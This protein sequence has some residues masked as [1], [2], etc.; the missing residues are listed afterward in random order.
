[1]N[2]RLPLNILITISLLITH[3]VCGQSSDQQKITLEDIFVK[4]IFSP[5]TLRG[6]NWMDDGQYYT[7]QVH[8]DTS[9]YE[10]ILKYD[11]TSG[12]VVDT[13]V[14]G[15][16][17][18]LE[19]EPVA[20]GV[21]ATG[22]PAMTFMGYT[23]SP[24]QQ[25]V[26]LATE[27]EPIYRRSS[28]AYYYLYDIA[29][30]NFQPLVSG[31]KQSYATFSPDGSKVAF[32]RN[33]N[34]FVV[35]LADMSVKQITQNGEKNQIINGSTDWVYE[36]E[37]GFAK[38]FYWSPESDKLAFLTFDESAVKEYNMQ[39][40]GD[41]YPDDYTFKYPKA[42]EKNS[43]LS[44]SVYHLD[45]DTTIT[46]NTGEEEDMYIP[47]VQWTQDDNI[48]S[49]IRLNRLQNQMELLHANATT[50]QTETILTE[51][52]DTYVD[53][54][55]NDALTYLENGE[56]FIHSS[57]K[58]GYKHLYLYNIDGSLIRQ[59]T[60]GDW[61]VSNFLGIDEQRN[62]LYYL[63]TEVSP[64]QRHLYSINLKG[65][66]KKKLTTQA[67]TYDANF[68]PDFRYYIQYYS[69]TMQP[70][71]ISLHQAPSGKLVRVVED[72]Q[73]LQED[74]ANYNLASKEFFS[75]TTDDQVTL[76]GYMIKPADFDSTKQYPVLMYV[77]GGPGS[78]TVINN[79]M[80]QRE[81]WFYFLAQKGYIV[82]SVDNR[83]T[84]G[85]GRDFRHV[86]YAQ[87][88]KYEVQ[89]QIAGAKYLGNLPY[90]D[91]D[92]I[93]I[94]GWSYGG[95]MTLLSLLMGNDVF[96]MGVAVAPVTNWR[97]YDTIY[98]ERYL[99]TPQLN[100]EGYDAYS[101]INHAA[102]LEG[103]LLLIHGT[104]DDNVH[105]Q[106]SIEMVDA[107]VAEGKQFESF[108]YPN[109]N[110]GIYGGNTRLHLFKMITD[111]VLKKL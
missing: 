33:N 52:S 91:Q 77:Y 68:S 50:G 100:P 6:I 109:R 88:G 86:T 37:F 97:F 11:I 9:Y 74:L 22:V 105:F 12:K 76:N 81:A 80:S 4:N 51:K 48:L 85:R 79:W 19:D 75:F 56:Q 66:H 24:D 94:W 71:H 38:A 102:K 46:I 2:T 98:T 3:A 20:T 64:L 78:Q 84:G 70:L 62:L 40:W 41:L 34:L 49:V 21:P 5:E 89:D 111:F 104:G 83:G 72:N 45:Q 90:V 25:K 55:A 87:L 23:L 61:E 93:G 53:I 95:Y 63:S 1:M 96:T 17:L 15:A 10:H 110:H 36:E 106:N 73:A 99:Q 39:W 30:N 27:L 59:I 14:N 92:R 47:R 54:E 43:T 103:D 58:D 8:D 7:S 35:N 108:Y 28:K 69:A 16:N 18:V 13:L 82:A 101:P 57:E 60:Q 29:N 32:V 107:L 31:D 44:I 42:G 67:G 26:L 65:Q